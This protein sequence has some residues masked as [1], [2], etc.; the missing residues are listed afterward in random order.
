MPIVLVIFLWGV[1]AV[2]V[3]IIMAWF[4]KSSK[5]IWFSGLGTVLTVFAL[6]LIAGLNNTSFYPSTSSLQSSLTILNSSSSQ[7]TLT[8]MSYVSLLVPFVL[9]YIFFAWRAIDRKKIDKA[10]M[11]DNDHVY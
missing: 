10:E 1:V 9:A 4:K 5:G 7:Y 3:G 8:V 6:L 11:K 2:L